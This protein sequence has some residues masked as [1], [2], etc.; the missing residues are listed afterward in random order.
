MTPSIEQLY[1]HPVL[2]FYWYYF[3]KEYKNLK[4]WRQELDNYRYA[5]PNHPLRNFIEMVDKYGK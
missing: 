3:K 4:L 2:V 1:Q 5:E